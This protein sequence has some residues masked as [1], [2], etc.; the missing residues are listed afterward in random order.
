MKTFLNIS[1]TV[2]ACLAL[3]GGCV[4]KE[5]VQQEL[6]SMDQRVST[7]EEQSGQNAQDISSMKQTNQ[8]QMDEF[9]SMAQDALDRAASAEKI[10]RGTLLHEIVM[11]EKTVQFGFD[12]T[13]LSDEAKGAMNDLV[14]RLTEENE[15]VYLEIQGH[16]DSTGEAAYN[17]RLGYKRAKRVLR[18][19]HEEFNIPLRRMSAYSYGETKPLM[20]N[21]SMENRMQNRRVAIVVMK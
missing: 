20:D 11:T 4:T 15:G 16:T 13:T 5:Y 14:G 1:I 6:A 18:Y 3:L 12:A 19:L 10:A 8:E 21:D 17:L 2:V 9:S 7:L